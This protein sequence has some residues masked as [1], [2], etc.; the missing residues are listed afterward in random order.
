MW[1]VPPLFFSPVEAPPPSRDH[2]PLEE[3][4]ILPPFRL[5][6]CFPDELPF[7]FLRFF[8]ALF[9]CYHSSSF[10]GSLRSLH[11]YDRI[12]SVSMGFKGLLD[13]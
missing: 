10:A 11:S 5:L 13:E 3:A 2:A 8:I 1:P 9:C 4:S 12:S 6:F 7:P